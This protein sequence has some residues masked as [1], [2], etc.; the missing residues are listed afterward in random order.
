MFV[1]EE[2]KDAEDQKC[3]Q[4]MQQN[5]GEMEGERTQSSE[6]VVQLKRKERQR[7]IEL[8]VITHKNRLQV[9]PGW[10]ADRKILH[11]QKPV[12]HRRESMEKRR[13]ESEEGEEEQEPD[14][15]QFLSFHVISFGFWVPGCK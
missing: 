3:I 10:S 13:P 4:S 5:I 6:E 15:D 2:L 11:D 14:G 7:D 8:R 1:R 9:F 12:I